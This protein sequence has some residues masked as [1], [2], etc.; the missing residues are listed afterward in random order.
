[1]S[2]MNSLPPHDPDDLPVY[3]SVIKFLGL[4][5]VLSI[6]GIITLS[7]L[8]KPIPD[9]VV[10]L[11]SGALGALAGVLA[12]SPARSGRDKLR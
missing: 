2:D 3:L 8:D 12:P 1:M 4:V 6:A 7:M 10:A 5:T 11:G 9:A